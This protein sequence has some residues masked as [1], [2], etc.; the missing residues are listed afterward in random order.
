MKITIAGGAGAMGSIFG[1]RLFQSGQDVLLYDIAENAVNKINEEGLRITDKNGAT[2][3][4]PVRASADP[5]DARDSEVVI[6]FTKCFHTET[7]VRSLQPHLHNH[8]K[9]LSLQ[10]GWGN[11][12]TISNI[13]GKEDL[14][15]GVN[16]VS[17]TLLE[18]GSV[19]QAG[20]P[21]AYIGRWNQ[22][23]DEFTRRFSEILSHAGVQTTP[24]N[25]V[26]TEIWKKLA[27]NVATLP[28][29]ALLRFQAHLLVAYESML[30]LMASLLHETIAV[31][32]AQ[33]IQ[34]DFEERMTSITN[35]LKN[36]I[37]AKGSMLQD[38]EANRRTEIDVI[39][40]AIVN[41][42]LQLSIA[43]PFNQAMLLLVK[44]LEQNYLQ[45]KQS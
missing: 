21:I 15:I 45:N 6:I 23:A 18:P 14:L 36:A 1:G 17:G 31:A 39:N 37:G 9:I 11:A 30:Q 26:I 16:Y 19:K 40:G 33:N 13:T 29:A 44:S 38:V 8:T 4:I 34:L 10:N 27:L 28:T 7:A 42:G 3:I 22:T 35:L 41:A 43:T 20:N 32:N 25:D 5:S 24:S 12:Q 2:Q